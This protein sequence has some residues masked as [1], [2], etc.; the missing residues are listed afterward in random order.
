[1]A[2]HHIRNQQQ[3]L[4]L[5]PQRH[6]RNCEKIVGQSSHLFGNRNLDQP[7]ELEQ[8]RSHNQQQELELAQEHIRNQQQGQVL[9]PQRHIRNRENVVDQSSHLL[10]NHNVDQLQELEHRRNHNR[11]QGL[12]LLHNRKQ[13]L[14]QQ[15]PALRKKGHIRSHLVL[16]QPFFE[17]TLSSR[18]LHRNHSLVLQIR[19]R[20]ILQPLVLLLRNRSDNNPRTG[21]RHPQPSSAAASQPQDSTTS[22][23]AA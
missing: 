18:F 9:L 8:L 11:Q 2:Q 23:A 13:E 17:A 14:R 5:L 1:L 6:I 3:G 21:W 20:M 16:D 7:Q 15:E 12:P 22:G 19:N 4:R 10:G